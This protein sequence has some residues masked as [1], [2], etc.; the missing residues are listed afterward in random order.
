MNGPFICLSYMT[1]MFQYDSSNHDKSNGI[2]KAEKICQQRKTHLLLP[3]VS[4]TCT[5]PLRHAC[6]TAGVHHYTNGERVEKPDNFSLI[7]QRP[8]LHF[9]TGIAISDHFVKLISWC[10]NEVG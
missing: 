7:L 8:F 5:C 10:D 1:Y 3:R 9:V 2:I 4:S 6:R